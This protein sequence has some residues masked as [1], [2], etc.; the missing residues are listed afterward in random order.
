MALPCGSR[1]PFLSVTKT[2]ALIDPTFLCGIAEYS[3]EYFIDVAQLNSEVK[4]S[5]QHRLREFSYKLAVGQH[6]C[7][8]IKAFVPD[9]RGVA[10]YHLIGVFARNVVLCQFQQ[11]LS[12]ENRSAQRFQILPHSIGIDNQSI[13]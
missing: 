4:N 13:Y 3:A 5:V 7:P 12:A 11:Q 8:K 10:L 1:T 2:F 6:S 9:A